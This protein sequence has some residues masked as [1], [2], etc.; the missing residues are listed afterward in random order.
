[1]KHN[2]GRNGRIALVAATIQKLQG[3]MPDTFAQK[4][5]VRFWA[6]PLP[7]GAITN[8]GK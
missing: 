3:T 2:V 1:M 6:S 8:M 4:D 5:L 7:I